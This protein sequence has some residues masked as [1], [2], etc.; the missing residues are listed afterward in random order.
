MLHSP[1]IPALP[2]G[3]GLGCPCC[4]PVPTGTLPNALA[5]VVGAKPCRLGEHSCGA[6]G[7]KRAAP[8]REINSALYV[9]L[10]GRLG[11]IPTGLGLS[12][13][14][15]LT[16]ALVAPRYGHSPRLVLAVSGGTVGRESPP[17]GALGTGG[18][19]SCPG[20]GPPPAGSNIPP[21]RRQRLQQEAP[22]VAGQEP[23]AFLKTTSPVK[24]FL[25]LMCGCRSQSC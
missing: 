24:S 12:C 16:P 11:S 8:A 19:G 3:V 20:G 1:P 9:P 6:E 7:A 13:G 23:G 21:A 22:L 17:S 4:C 18:T 14:R 15:W 25:F 10:S 5:R 2:G